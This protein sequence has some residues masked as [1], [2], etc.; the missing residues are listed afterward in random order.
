VGRNVVTGPGSK[1][2]DVGL[3]KRIAIRENHKV[4]FRCEMFNIFNFVNL[5][6]VETRLSRTNFGQVTSAGAPRILQFGLKYSF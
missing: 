2:F 4:E 5:A 3:F 6:N 1:N